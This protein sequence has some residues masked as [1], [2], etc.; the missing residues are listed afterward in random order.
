[1][2]MKSVRPFDKSG[3]IFHH[4]YSISCSV[5]KEN[6]FYW[7]IIR[8]EVICTKQRAQ[9]KR[10]R[11]TCPLIYRVLLFFSPVSLWIV[12]WATDRHLPSFETDPKLTVAP[13]DGSIGL[14]MRQILLLYDK[15]RGIKRILAVKHYET[16][17]SRYE[18]GLGVAC[19]PA[20]RPNRL[21]Y[22]PLTNIINE[23]IQ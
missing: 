17:S 22:C 8:M 11:V 3:T 12:S 14:Q 23:R 7:T 10:R 19:T 5:T 1:M 4:Y 15:S 2:G 16:R 6:K 18:N 20:M 21:T 13:F 9:S